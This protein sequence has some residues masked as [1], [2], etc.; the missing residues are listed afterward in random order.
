MR[1]LLD[2]CL[3]R[4][5]QQWLSVARPDWVAMTVQNAGWAAMKNG[6]L[7]R[8]ANGKFDVL[9]TADKNM[10]H[11]QN[12]T[13]LDISVLVFPANRIKLV[14]LGVPAILQS[15]PRVRQGE[16]TIMDLGATPDWGG[17]VLHDVI[18]EE[19]GIT[20]HVFSN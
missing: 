6:V 17:A 4:Q 7:L 16:K 12:F 14:R 5:L 15:L 18:A 19:G 3:P 20:R 13:G 9:L 11:Q 1:A 2:E 10:H 8:A